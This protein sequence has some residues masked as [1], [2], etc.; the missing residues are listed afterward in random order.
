M[1]LCTL[2]LSIPFTALPESLAGNGFYCI[3]D[4]SFP[5]HANIG[6]LASSA[7]SCSLCAVVQAGVEAWMEK[8]ET[9]LQQKVLDPEAPR[10]QYNA[11]IPTDNRLFLVQRSHSAPGF[12]V[13]VHHPDRNSRAYLLTGVA[14]SVAATAR[15]P[16]L[17]SGSEHS[18]SVASSL[19]KICQDHHD[20]CSDKEALL[21]VLHVGG[22]GQTIKLI[23]TVQDQL[24]IYATLSYC[25]GDAANLTTTQASIDTR[26]SGIQLSDLPRTFHDAVKICRYFG[27]DYLWIDSLCICQ[28]DREDWARQSARMIDIYSKSHLVIAANRATDSNDGIFHIRPHRSPVVIDVPGYGKDIHVQLIINQDEHD[29]ARR[30]FRLLGRHILHYNTRQMY[31]ECDRGVVGEDRSVQSSRFCS[32]S[33]LRPGMSEYGPPDR[34]GYYTW[35]NVLAAYGSR[36]LTKPTDKL[37]AMSGLAALFQAKVQAEYVAGIWDKSLVKGLAWQGILSEKLQ[38]ATPDEYTGPSWSWV[39]YHGTTGPIFNQDWINLAESVDWDVELKTE[40]NPFGEVQSAWLRIRGPMT[41]LYAAE[42]ATQKEQSHEDKMRR[43]GLI[44]E[45]LMRTRCSKDAENQSIILDYPNLAADGEWEKLGLHVLLLG[46]YWK[47]K[48]NGDPPPEAESFWNLEEDI[49]SLFK[50]FYGLVVTEANT[51][52]DKGEMRRVGCVHISPEEVQHIRTDKG[53]RKTIVLV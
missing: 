52:R 27:I 15:L 6:A 5:W 2:C 23:D 32:L 44:P 31:Y 12:L 49:S 7:Q 45:P 9:A 18:L 33:V 47:H 51:G 41:P 37:P 13:Y 14:F 53:N 36:Y 40:T 28:D 25:W 17:D 4:H 19:W 24:G 29:V 1:G 35:V 10:A 20:Q 30:G 26:R 38:T 50:L 39:G 11:P 42:E 34:D 43:A 46:G 21:R 48:S 3:Y 22:S 8:R 16:D